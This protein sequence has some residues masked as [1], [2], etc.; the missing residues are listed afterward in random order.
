MALQAL[1]ARA[2][3]SALEER[4]VAESGHF[5]NLARIWVAHPLRFAFLAKGGIRCC[6]PDSGYGQATVALERK[7]LRHFSTAK[8][9]F[10]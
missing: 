6:L 5:F 7:P 4:R 2:S 8:L 1:F 10:M 3:S 9:H